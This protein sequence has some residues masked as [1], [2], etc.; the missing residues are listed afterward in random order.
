MDLRRVAFLLGLVL[1]GPVLAQGVPPAVTMPDGTTQDLTA[2]D[3]T[4]IQ[5]VILR[6]L[7][8]FRTDDAEAAYAQAAPNIRALFPTADGFMAMVRRGYPPVYRPRSAEF[9]ELAMRDGELVQEVELVGPDGQAVLAL[10]TMRRMPDGTW[11]IAGCAL[12]PSARLGV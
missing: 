3:R 2:P 10:Y 12:I 1:A 8:A 5:G 11:A 7:D 6:Q 4:A 9:S